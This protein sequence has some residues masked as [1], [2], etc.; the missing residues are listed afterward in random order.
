MRTLQ[1]FLCLILSLSL[2]AQVETVTIDWGVNSNPTATGDFNTSRTIEVGDTVV[3][4]WIGS[5]THNVQS[6]PDRVATNTES[7]NSGVPVLTPNSFSYTF[8]T[9]GSTEYECA[10]N[11]ALMFGTITVVPE[12]SLSTPQFEAPS[13]FSIFPNPSSDVLNINIPTLTDGGLELEIFDVLGK[14]IYSQQ[15]GELSSSI[16]VAKWN[17]G[18]YLVRIS[19]PDQD[20]TLTKRFV[21]L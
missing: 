12:G 1:F 21:K 17:S 4:T 19:S 8:N 10:L 9:I 15:L 20:I 18:L 6:N 14:K 11:R 13:K 2:S 3:W 5:G 16:N 7:I